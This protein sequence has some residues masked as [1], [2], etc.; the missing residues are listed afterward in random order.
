MQILVKKIT[1][2][3]L[4]VRGNPD[5]A[6]YDVF[7]TSE[8]II[9]GEKFE[10]YLDGIINAWSKIDYI[11]YKT[12]LFI[13][14]QNLTKSKQITKFHSLLLPRSS[15]CKKNLVLANS[16]GL[17]D[18]GYRGEIEFRFKYIAQPE[19]MLV[20]PMNGKTRIYYQISPNNIYAKGDRIGQ[21]MA[22]PNIDI[23]FC[24]SENLDNTARNNG[25]FG[26]TN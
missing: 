20:I 23:D 17:V 16:I 13:S 26:S 7:A 11:A 12:N 9:V 4:P 2:L 22:S 24:L 5:D 8:P 3:N 19:D 15:I 21:I 1:G 10:N 18:N 6:A 14:P 25:G